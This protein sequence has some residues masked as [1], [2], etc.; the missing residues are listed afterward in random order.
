MNTSKVKQI[1]LL[2][3]IISGIIA[4][5]VYSTYAIFTLESSTSDILNINTP[6]I[7]NIS[8]SISEY[9]QV[10]VPKNSYIKTDIDIYNNFDYDVCYSVWY[11]TVNNEQNDLNKIK[12][13]ENTSNS[14]TTSSTIAPHN[15]IRIPLIITNDNDSNIKVNIGMSYSQNEGTCELNLGDNKSLINTT[16]DN[17]KNL[18]TELIKNVK[19]VNS[20]PGYLIYKNQNNPI[21]LD[22]MSKIYISEKF[23]YQNELFTLTDQVE[24]DIDKIIEYN[25][26]E[27]KNY[28]TCLTES[29]CQVLYHLIENVKKDKNHYEIAKY[30]TLRGYLGGKT[31]LRK[32]D[33]DYYYFGDN[34]HNYVYY[35]C[36]NNI[37]TNSCEL[38]RII[39]FIYDE[40]KQEYY[41]KIIRNDYITNI[42]YSEINNNWKDSS[43]T[44]YLKEYKVNDY[45]L[46]EREFKT[47]NII[48]WDNQINKLQD[49]IKDKIF[50]MNLTDYLNASVCENK[51][52]NEYDNNCLNN[53]WLNKNSNV[54]EWTMTINYQAPYLDENTNETITP[55]NNLVYS[56][57]NSIEASLV[58][59]K[60]NVRPVIYL[61]PRTFLISGDGSF[62]NPYVI[63]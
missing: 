19:E 6:D 42:Q 35:N 26:S 36:T 39:G 7:L 54:N 32:I 49:T 31:G 52:V 4:L 60:L 27:T 8:S 12:L 20:E 22:D 62:N 25:S 23:T 44:E 14:L 11:T 53:N 18:S 37:D 33:N 56:V 63:K 21:N 59:N 9:K 61:T 28:Y 15:S 47:E 41:A 46:K 17:P 58:T 16:I 43:I 50:I 13:Y 10:N 3:I 45:L 1:Y 38:W 48:D 30:D 34:A 57:G 24:I 40:E 55:D 2:T 29:N 51:K 5:S